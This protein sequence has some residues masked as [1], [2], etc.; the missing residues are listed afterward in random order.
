MDP[1]IGKLLVAYELNALSEE[2]TELIENHLMV[3]DHC[4]N[5]LESFRNEAALLSGDE[6][7]KGIVRDA[8]RKDSGSESLLRK[9]RRYVWP[10]VPVV[11]KPALAYLLILI[12]LIP[13]YQGFLGQDDEQIG[14][15]QT[16]RLLPGR[17]GSECVLDANSDKQG[18]LSFVFRGAV[19]GE[20]YSVVILTDDGE[21]IF[22]DDSFDGFDQYE[23]GKLL[24]P[25]DKMTPGDYR[26]VITDRRV[27]APSGRREYNFRIGR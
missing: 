7:I 23:T 6:N 27:D 16:V 3:C 17:S 14:P 25:L 8:A 20:N 13:A 5:E 22:R 21:E 2:D 19:A 26:L 15:V 24:I 18:L 1:K 11:F 10:D 12:L 9:L 4:F